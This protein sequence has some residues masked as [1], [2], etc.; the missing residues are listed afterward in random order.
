MD[1]DRMFYNAWGAAIMM[2]GICV[3]LG[4]FMEI[5]AGGIFMFWLLSVGAILVVAGAATLQHKPGVART[6]IGG[7]MALVV[8][9]AGVLA[10]ALKLLHPIATLAIIIIFVG[11]GIMAMGKK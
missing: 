1:G 11:I 5:G 4:W 6:Q 7:G 10:V 3:I 8:L 2:L 9:S